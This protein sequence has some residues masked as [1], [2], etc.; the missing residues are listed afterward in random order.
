MHCGGDGV[1]K[2]LKRMETGAMLSEKPPDDVGAR[3]VAVR[4]GRR[5]SRPSKR[6]SLAWPKEKKEEKTSNFPQYALRFHP[7][8]WNIFLYLS[9]RILLSLLKAVGCRNHGA[10]GETAKSEQQDRGN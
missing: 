4:L 1:D 5:S 3:L 7:R 6:R 9:F 8:C 10:S 2:E